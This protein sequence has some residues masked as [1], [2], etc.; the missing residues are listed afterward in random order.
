MPKAQCKHCGH[1]RTVDDELGMYCAGCGAPRLPFAAFFVGIWLL[2]TATYFIGQLDTDL[3]Q[4]LLTVVLLVSAVW[5]SV[6]IMRHRRS[7]MVKLLA[8][9]LPTVVIAMSIPRW[10]SPSTL[11]WPGVLVGL[12]FALTVISIVVI[13]GAFGFAIASGFRRA[14]QDDGLKLDSLIL[15]WLTLIGIVITIA[16]FAMPLI[17]RALRDWLRGTRD[18]E[19]VRNFLGSVED[20]LQFVV[21]IRY[22][23]ILILAF[24]LVGLA[25]VA[26]LRD[27]Y[28][29]EGAR[30]SLFS[31]ISRILR[32]IVSN[33]VRLLWSTIERWWLILLG[34]L[35]TSAIVLAGVVFITS[36]ATVAGLT[37]RLWLGDAFVE[38]PFHLWL[39]LLG[40]VVAALA[41]VVVMNGVVSQD[42]TTF[43]AAIGGVRRDALGLAQAVGFSFFI[44]TL[45]FSVAWI[46][47]L[48]HRGV[49]G[50]GGFGGLLFVVTLVAYASFALVSWLR[51]DKSP[52]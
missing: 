11:A 26:A 31:T 13:L 6:L 16:Y 27:H 30:F 8:V 52:Q 44:V 49:T 10:G 23:L 17:T 51:R 15:T 20:G 32:G 46:I 43:R 47:A 42:F 19:G 48:A 5:S 9:F 4:P 24:A 14:R 35:P 18:W 22:V 25:T 28:K 33:V 39:L 36:I 45:A 29:F 50:A 21:D 38:L 7:A 2:V 41:S 37:K 40:D 34:I 12:N 3:L 1:A